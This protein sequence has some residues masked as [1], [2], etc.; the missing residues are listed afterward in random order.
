MRRSPSRRP[1]SC[2]ARTSDRHDRRHQGR[3]GGA[4]RRQLSFVAEYNPLFGDTA[5]DVVMKTLAGE[6]VE[7]YIIVPSGTFDSPEAAQEALPTR[8]Y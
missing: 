5:V 6:T 2:P 1:G 4:R 8:Q 3:H 7:S